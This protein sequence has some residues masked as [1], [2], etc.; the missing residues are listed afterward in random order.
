MPCYDAGPSQAEIE[1]ENKVRRGAVVGL[2]RACA[3]LSLLDKLPESLRPWYEAHRASDDSRDWLDAAH[4]ALAEE[5]RD[6]RKKGF[7]LNRDHEA[8]VRTR[9]C[10]E[11]L[12]ECEAVERREQAKLADMLRA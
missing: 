1:F 3:L 2:C 12:R 8:Y 6:A 7:D 10:S 9:G 4:A 11:K 5:I